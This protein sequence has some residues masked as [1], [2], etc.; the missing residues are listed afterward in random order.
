MDLLDDRGKEY[1]LN[2]WQDLTD[3]GPYQLILRSKAKN[4]TIREAF[5]HLNPFNVWKQKEQN[6]QKEGAQTAK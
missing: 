5:L 1:V 3:Y 4:P 6:E 2:A